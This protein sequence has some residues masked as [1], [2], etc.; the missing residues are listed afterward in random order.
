MS[1][2][3]IAAI[4]LGVG[5][6]FVR[7]LAGQRVELKS[8]LLMPVILTVIGAAEIKNLGSASAVAIGLAAVGVLVS[9]LIGTV[10]GGTIG[11]GAREGHLWMRYRLSTILLWVVNIAVKAAL[12]PLAGFVGGGA[13]TLAEQSIMLAI[14]CGILAESGVVYLRSVRAARELGVE[15]V[16]STDRDGAVLTAP[17]NPA[18]G[19]ADTTWAA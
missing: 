1:P 4:V 12:I 8:L 6:L 14:G 18:R 9:V 13:S 10:R 17:T 7:R 3:G 2:I 5:Y 16:W 19:G 11:F 15:L